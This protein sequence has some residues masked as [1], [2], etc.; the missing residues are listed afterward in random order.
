MSAGGDLVESVE[1]DQDCAIHPLR[2]HARDCEPLG[3]V[4]QLLVRIT[5][6]L[7][8]LPREAG[9]LLHEP[10]GEFY[11]IGGVSSAAEVMHDHR[12]VGV[13]RLPAGEPV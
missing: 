9:D 13:C 11:R 8:N 7:E 12:R 3:K 2:P 4:V 6:G 5:F 1:D 10:H